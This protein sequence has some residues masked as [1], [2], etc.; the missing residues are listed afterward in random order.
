LKENHGGTKAQRKY[1]GL[2]KTTETRMENGR[3]I[4][5][6]SYGKCGER[7]HI[8][9]YHNKTRNKLAKNPKKRRVAIF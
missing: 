7:N 9:D 2:K 5:E 4:W 3:K 8:M 1:F 6:M